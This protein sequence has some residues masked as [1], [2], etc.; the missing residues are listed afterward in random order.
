MENVEFEKLEDVLKIASGRDKYGSPRAGGSLLIGKTS[1]SENPMI[2]DESELLNV[3]FDIKMNGF[4]TV[5][6]ADFPLEASVDY[7]KAMS[8]IESYEL[9]LAED[10]VLLL[11]IVPLVLCGNISLVYQDLVHAEGYL[12]PDGFYRIVFSFDTFRAAVGIADDVDYKEIEYAIE[13]EMKR[14]HDKYDQ[15][16]AE[17]EDE[18]KETENQNPF[19][20]YKNRFNM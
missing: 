17:A 16:I 6:I 1:D 7:K 9:G 20:D 10:E 14:I 2:I 15:Q 18:L 11:Q 12:H 8:M 13:M 19:N 3:S 5:V 4:C